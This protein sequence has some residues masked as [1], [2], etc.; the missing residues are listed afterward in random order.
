MANEAVLLVDDNVSNLKLVKVLLQSKNYDLRT[1]LNAGETFSV[2]T[3]FQP[4]LILM[5]IQLPDING[6]EITKKLRAD[7]KYNDVV[8]L[9]ITAYAMKGDEERSLAAGCDGYIPKP[10]DTRTLPHIIEK[11][12][13]EGRKRSSRITDVVL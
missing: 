5:D 7:S 8:I 12:L 11:W 3:T 13:S 2:L 4:K 1:A 6:L 9:A 10:I